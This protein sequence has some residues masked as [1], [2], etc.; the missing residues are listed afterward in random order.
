MN[1]DTSSYWRKVLK[2]DE[3]NICDV[4]LKCDRHLISLRRPLRAFASLLFFKM[5]R[6]S[7]SGV[8]NLPEKAPFIIASNHASSFDFPAV[9]LCLPKFHRDKVCVIYKGLYDKIPFA[10][11]FIKS[12]APSFSV[13][14]KSDFLSAM[15]TAA[16]A[17]MC[18]RILY[19]APEGTRNSGEIL[20][21]K[22]GVGAL[23][24][25]TGTP[26]VPAYIKG[27][28]K[29]LPR[30]SFIPRKHP[31]KVFFGK[32]LDPRPYFEKKKSTAAYDV[33]KEFADDLRLSIIRLKEKA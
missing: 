32:P 15:S 12:F 9:F 16:N 8:E 18:G 17:L 21:F 19:I 33:Y 27:S 4:A 5:F 3:L 10:R 29:A 24:V 13:D 28:D 11:M 20:P 22:V 26:V 1:E 23:A 6:L 25:E 31:I 2:L 7:S 30:G 14:S